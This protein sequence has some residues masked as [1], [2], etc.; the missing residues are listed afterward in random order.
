MGTAVEDQR[1][2]G[3]GGLKNRLAVRESPCAE[4][5]MADTLSLGKKRSGT[6]P[7]KNTGQGPAFFTVLHENIHTRAFLAG[8]IFR[9][10][11]EYRGKESRGSFGYFYGRRYGWAVSGLMLFGLMI[12]AL[13]IMTAFM[14][15]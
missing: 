5:L 12:E 15:G 2:S 3:A 7:V 13:V 8:R 6:R 10:D 9:E 4:I 14:A 11:K 1:G